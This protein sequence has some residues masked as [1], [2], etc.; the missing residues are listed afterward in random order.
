MEF[1]G[2]K[3]RDSIKAYI[4]RM[5]RCLSDDESRE[6]LDKHLP[7]EAIDMLFERFAGR[8]R[9]AAV[10][11]VS[12]FASTEIISKRKEAIKCLFSFFLLTYLFLSIYKKRLLRATSRT[13]G[14][15]ISRSRRRSWYLGR[16]EKPKAISATSSV[17]YTTNATIPMRPRN[18]STKL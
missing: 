3:N 1:P 18:L 12:L 10:A 7:Q 8:F 11:I 9:P 17:V 4:S 2:W 5:R 16:T 15:M 14:G 6:V 13:Y